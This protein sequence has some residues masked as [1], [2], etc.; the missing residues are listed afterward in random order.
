MPDLSFAEQVSRRLTQDLMGRPLLHYAQISSTNLEMKAKAGQGWPHGAC[1]SADFQSAGR[2][3]LN[4]EWKAQPGSSLLFSLLLRPPAIE[5]A[6]TALAALAVSQALEAKNLRP[7]IKWPNDIYLRGAKLCGMLS[8]AAASAL[9]IGIGLN[10]NQEA[11]ELAGMGQEAVSL[12]TVSGQS[13]D[14]PALLADI[15]NHF[16]GL[17]QKWRQDPG[18]WLPLYQERCWLLGKEVAAVDSDRRY[19]GTAVAVTADGSLLLDTADGRL[20]LRCGDVSVRALGAEKA[21]K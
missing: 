21:E 17:C 11:A 13:W 16:A 12:K 20:A 4:R 14:R 10:V 6:F 8:E 18:F 19:Q 3:R 15:L 7:Q 1:L 2:G 9:I 5:F